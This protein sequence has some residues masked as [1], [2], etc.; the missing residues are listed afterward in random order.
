MKIINLKLVNIIVLLSLLFTSCILDKDKAIKKLKQI[1]IINSEDSK[2][3]SFT[4]KYIKKFPN[5]IELYFYRG[6]ANMNTKN[7]LKALDDFNKCLIINSNSNMGYKGLA[8]LYYK[9]YIYNKDDKHAILSID[10]FRK[11]IQLTKI[12]KEKSAIMAEYA[13]VLILQEKYKEALRL[14]NKSKTICDIGDIYTIIGFNYRFQNDM[15]NA[16]KYWLEAIN[17]TNYYSQYKKALAYFSLSR[18]AFKNESNYKDALKYI[19]K[20]IS[21]YPKNENYINNRKQILEVYEE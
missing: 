5:E 2:T 9:K 8:Q 19:N 4:S 16:K 10:Y 3:I 15:I 12:Q 14:L 17:K 1:Y 21:I 13:K 6:L 7:Y 18:N 11:A 20:A